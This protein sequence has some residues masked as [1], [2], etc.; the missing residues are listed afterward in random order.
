MRLYSTKNPDQEIDFAQAVFHSLPADNGLYM[1]RPIPRLSDKILSALPDLSFQEVSLEI[2]RALLGGSLEESVLRTIIEQTINFPA[3]LRPL[4]EQSRVLELFHGPSMAFK[5]FGARFMSRVMA[6]YLQQEEKQLHILVATSGDTGGAVALGFYDVPRISVT[7]LYP[8]GKVSP[9]Q[10][11]QLTTLG[12]NISAIEVQGT[13]DDCQQLVKQAFLDPELNQSL[14]LSSAN[15]INIARLI[16]QTF[17]YFHAYSQLRKAGDQRPVVF[18]VPSG[19]FGNLTAGLIAWKMGLP[20]HRFVAATNIN[21][22]VPQYLT[23]GVFTPRPSAHTLSN[24][25]DVGNPS[26]FARMLDLFGSDVHQMSEILTGY[27]VTDE[28]TRKAIGEVAAR[29][30]YLMCPHTAVAYLGLQRYLSDDASGDL[31]GIFLSTAHPCKFPEVYGEAEKRLLEYP[32][33]AAGLEDEPKNTI[34]ME[35]SF[36][37]LREILL[38]RHAD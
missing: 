14:H 32:P 37:R 15:S 9:V 23:S 27:S 26:N 34:R 4:D 17:Y 11:K 22:E 18:S 28:D 29:H 6:H 2:A 3:P 36:D 30:Q 38:A 12:K 19:N 25:M 13:F 7:I 33:Q 1:P 16:P 8:S 5:D 35:V 20:V 31:A 24:A 10:E 21:D